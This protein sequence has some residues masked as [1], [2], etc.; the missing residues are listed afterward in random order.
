MTKEKLT[1]LKEIK[2]EYRDKKGIRIFVGLNSNNLPEIDLFKPSRK[3]FKYYSTTLK[4][5]SR[6][7]LEEIYIL[8]FDRICKEF[9]KDHKI[10][11]RWFRDKAG[12]FMYYGGKPLID[13]L[14]KNGKN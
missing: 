3:K 11:R 5:D 4:S 7:G 6:G 10:A 13:Y 8:K 2:F 12:S 9:L 14:S 1:D